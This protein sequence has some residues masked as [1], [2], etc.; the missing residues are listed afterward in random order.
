MNLDLIEALAIED[1]H[2]SG[3]LKKLGFE[4]KTMRCPQR[5]DP[6]VKT[7]RRESGKNKVFSLL[8]RG[9]CNDASAHFS[10]L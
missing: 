3:L 2:S 7:M 9:A 6:T 10:E 8:I 4:W 5:R 1:L